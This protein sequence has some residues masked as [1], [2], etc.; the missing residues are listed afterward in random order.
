MEL[1]RG[2]SL[3]DHET[4]PGATSFFCTFFSFFLSETKNTCSFLQD[5]QV[6]FGYNKLF[7][8]EPKGRSGGLALFYMDAFDVSILYFDKYMIDISA[9][10]EGHKV[11]MT[12]VYGDP[13]VEY[14]EYV[15]ERLTRMSTSR[16]GAW[17]MCG[18][19]NEIVSNQEKRGGRKRPETSFLP[20]KLMLNNCGMM[21][22]PYKGN[23]MSWVGYRSSGKVQCRLDRAVGNEDWHQFFSHTNVEYLKLWGSDHRPILTCIQSRTV[24][25]QRCFKF[26]RRWLYKDGFKESIEAG[27]GLIDP[28]PD[29]PLHVKIRD[30]R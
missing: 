11:F 2:R 21:E 6:S 7:T 1:S 19:F 17:L 28:D 10:I 30:V 4:S 16:T 25:L 15:W 26:D 22:F 24:R 23:S 18:D 8:V 13:V 3:L 14:R 27:W 29:R 5:F 9:M 12:F 20:F